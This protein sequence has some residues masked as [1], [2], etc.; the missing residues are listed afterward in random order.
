MTTNKSLWIKGFGVITEKLAMSELDYFRNEMQ[1]AYADGNLS[2]AI[3][4]MKNMRPFVEAL[5][6]RGY[7][8][9]QILGE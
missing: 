9:I 1:L 3:L 7:T 4:M 5:Q 6:E 8:M 2:R